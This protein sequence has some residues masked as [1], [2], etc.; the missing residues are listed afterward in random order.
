MP[1]TD[2]T[3][4]SGGNV[5]PVVI[6]TTLGSIRVELDAGSA[7]ITTANFLRHVDSGLYDSG[8]MHRTVTLENQNALTGKTVDAS[9]AI[10]VVQGGAD[11]DRLAEPLDPIPLERTNITGIRHIDGAISMARGAA[12]SAKE[13]FFI[14]VG[15]QPSLDFGGLRNPDGQGFAAFGRVTA[16]MEV[17]RAIHHAPHQGQRLDPPITITTITRAET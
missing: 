4:D 9:V 12:D 10:E 16:G 14:C 13:Q 2:Q 17:V 11:P 3:R 7:P 8:R 15:D 6:E 1:S 5:V